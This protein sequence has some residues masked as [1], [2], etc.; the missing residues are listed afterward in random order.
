[1]NAEETRALWGLGR[2]AW[3]EWASEIVKSKANFDD[4][5][6]LALN[7]F[8]E[9]ENDETRLWLKVATADF[10]G[11]HFDDEADFAG[12]N[13]PG[14]VDFT[15]AV[16]S[17]PVTFKAASFDLPAL[18]SRATFQ[19]DA[20]F[21]ETKFRG[22]ALFED[23]TFGATADFERAEFLK[24]NNGPL[25]AP[26][27]F[28]RAHFTGRADFRSAAFHGSL[29]FSKVKC[30]AVA[31]FDEAQIRTDATFEGTIF[32]GVVS[33]SKAQLAGNTKFTE[34]QFSGDARF[35]E[36]V[37]KA[38]ANFD[39]AQVW[40]NLSL[41][42]A[43]LEQ[44]ASFIDMR[45]E[46]DARLRNAKFGGKADFD[47]VR[48]KG[49][50]DLGEAEFAGPAQFR[51]SHFGGPLRAVACQFR[52]SLDFTG[53]AFGKGAD[54]QGSTFHAPA[55]FREARFDGPVSFASTMFNA[56]A[57]FSAIQSRV[58]FVL[59]DA[60]FGSVPSFLEASF[61]EPPRVDHMSVTDP[62]RRWNQWSTPGIS[63]PRPHGFRLMKVCADPDASAK[64]RRLKKLAFEAQD[65]TRE[66]E[67]YAQE[68]RCRRFWYDRPFGRG[69]A[70][71]WLGWFYGGMANFGRSMLRPFMLWF[72][73]IFV[74]ALYYLSQ[75]DIGW[76][77]AVSGAAAGEVRKSSFWD[78]TDRAFAMFSS[79]AEG[80]C[81]AAKSSPF[82]EAVYLSFRNALLM[83]G[84]DDEDTA[85][86]VFGCLY[87]LDGPYPIVPLS[88]SAV[89]LL[90]MVM[91]AI[92][93]FMFL[94]ALRNLLKVR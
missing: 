43:R 50:T 63:D 65:Q 81:V 2:D 82:G 26:A 47:D 93:I 91:S 52:A 28:Q 72:A 60:S 87:G 16:F 4:A 85:R 19:Q 30:A 18:F 11:V 13:F 62:L 67:F 58:A 21:S 92:L 75:R 5:G 56:A 88:V 35:G 74:F 41:R 86:R 49:E 33:F 9:A 38:P 17:R 89:S 22:L 7:W 29:D 55:T 1:M 70:K 36:A 8:G 23:A 20:T 71:F 12:F 14:P 78:W 83:T 68:L 27:K 48:V 73:S 31:R 61:H 53:S 57:D 80:A 66:Q 64:Y 6:S 90:Q 10:S 59:A 46:G 3:N 39:R 25:S 45:V 40:A 42:D 54:F 15:G 84:W 34:A 77:A 69:V 24:E 94:L 79:A 44:D 32:A 76:S 37:F 51:M